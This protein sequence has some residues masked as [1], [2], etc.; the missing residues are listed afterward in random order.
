MNKFYSLLETSVSTLA[1]CCFAGAAAAADVTSEGEL[2]N[3]LQTGTDATLVGD[4]ELAGNL[5]AT[6]GG[7]FTIDGNGHTLSGALTGGSEEEEPL[8]S[9]SGFNFGAGTTVDITNLTAV[10]LKQAIN[11][12]GT[13]GKIE[14]SVFEN[15]MASGVGA[16]VSG[17]AINNSGT[18]GEISGSV[19][20]GNSV[21]AEG[22]DAFGGAIAN[23]GGQALNLIN[24]SFYN[25]YAEVTGD[26]AYDT[27][28][29]PAANVAVG[30][31]IYSNGDVNITARGQDVVFSGNMIV[32]P[33]PP[34]EEEGGEGAHPPPEEP[35][36]E[37]NQEEAQ[38]E[39]AE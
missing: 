25:N 31:A 14:N 32:K 6:T 8:P 38:P 3:A 16:D 35:Q 21:T 10:T 22:G 17:G 28:E 1:L 9:V 29:T 20:R 7:S 30:G 4:I 11:N 33:E 24:T 15:N 19:F 5:P 2:A 13:I 34:E 27:E 39:E 12:S 23:T 26:T 18:I 36:Q 37:E